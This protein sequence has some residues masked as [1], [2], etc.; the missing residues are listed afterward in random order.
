MS[1]LTNFLKIQI[2]NCVFHLVA[3]LLIIRKVVISCIILKQMQQKIAIWYSPANLRS[4][5][6]RWFYRTSPRVRTPTP[7]A[8]RVRRGGDQAGDAAGGAL[9]CP[10]LVTCHVLGFNLMLNISH[11]ERSDRRVKYVFDISDN[12]HDLR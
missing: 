12:F 7:G 11:S 5:H 3:Y 6:V 4:P 9:A 2:C 10:V 8:I 1:F